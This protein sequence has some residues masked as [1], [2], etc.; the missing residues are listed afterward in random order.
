[1]S[2]I[3]RQPV[4]FQHDNLL[5]RLG[6]RSRRRQT[7][8]ASAEDNG[9]LTNKMGCHPCLPRLLWARGGAPSI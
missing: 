3:R 5:E 6:E 4:A 8:H 2:G 7:T 9:S 1:M